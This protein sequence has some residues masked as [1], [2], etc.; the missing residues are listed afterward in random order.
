MRLW[1]S[2]E[3]V[4]DM[5]I[6]RPGATGDEFVPGPMAVVVDKLIEPRLGYS[7]LDLHSPE[8]ECVRHVDETSLAEGG[9]RGPT[10]LAGVKYG[11][12]TSFFTR[13]AQVLGLMAKQD[14]KDSK[15]PTVAVLFRDGD[16][17]RSVPKSAWQ[18]KFDSIKRGFALVD[19]DC[20]VPMVPRPKSE[21]WLLCGLRQP[22]YTHCAKL[23]DASGNDDSPKS[24]KA[25]LE[26]V[27]GH[28]VGAAEQADWVRDGTIDP[29]RITMP[30][31]DAFRTELDRALAV[32]MA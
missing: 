22:A 17:T 28:A 15:Q 7:L 9:K 8:L 25:Q 12:N 6:T 32:A 3:G 4:T 11:K 26:T 23:E 16:G 31:F 18:E 21:A 10:L 2:G 30:S 13:K 5:E 24:M 14:S 20:G 27:A 29:H 19:F 1:L